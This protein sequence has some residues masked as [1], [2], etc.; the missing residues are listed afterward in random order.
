MLTDH[1]QWLCTAC[2][3]L[4]WNLVELVCNFKD[5]AT[6]WKDLRQ[7]IIWTEVGACNLMR[8]HL[9]LGQ[10]VASGLDMP[11]KTDGRFLLPHVK[12]ISNLGTVID[13]TMKSSI[14]RSM[15]IGIGID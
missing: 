13:S 2:R 7:E 1:F 12:Q 14:Q 4:R 3:S 8:L 9:H 11:N 6:S 5:M 15:V 10:C